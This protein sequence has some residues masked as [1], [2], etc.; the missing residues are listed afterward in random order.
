MQTACR[1]IFVLRKYFCSIR[2]LLP[3]ANSLPKRPLDLSS[4]SERSKLGSV[5]RSCQTTRTRFPHRLFLRRQNRTNSPWHHL[6]ESSQGPAVIY[7]L[8]SA[9]SLPLSSQWRP[10]VHVHISTRVLDRC[11]PTSVTS[12]FLSCHSSLNLPRPVDFA[13]PLYP[14][15]SRLYLSRL[16]LRFH[17]SFLNSNL[18]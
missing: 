18:F 4:T 2:A 6:R 17:L 1:H 14:S 3:R 15:T 8:D 13:S 10:S 16:S 9:S 5:L 11:A 12:Q 7:R